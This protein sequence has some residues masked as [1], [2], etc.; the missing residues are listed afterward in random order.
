[1]EETA[2][3]NIAPQLSLVTSFG[4]SHTYS[5]ARETHLPVPGGRFPAGAR[6]E[7][8]Y[9]ELPALRE[10]WALLQ[11]AQFVLIRP[12]PT[13]RPSA[14]AI[15]YLEILHVVTQAFELARRLAIECDIRDPVTHSISL[16]NVLGHELFVPG[17]IPSTFCKTD[18]IEEC[19][20]FRP[21]DGTD[22]V[23]ARAISLV[24]RLYPHFGWRD[25]DPDELRRQQ[26]RHRL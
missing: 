8:D 24:L 7:T 12:L 11:S 25:A 20:E 13:N 4:N 21:F 15:H 18:K 10:A 23:F 3:T 6:G 17:R 16:V 1:V 26:Q 19:E 2:R 22:E 14:N 5:G 9:A